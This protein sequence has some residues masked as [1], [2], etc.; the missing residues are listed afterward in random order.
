[1]PSGTKAQAGK[2]LATERWFMKSSSFVFLKTGFTLTDHRRVAMR[3]WHIYS[4]TIALAF[5]LATA[6]SLFRTWL[7]RHWEIGVNHV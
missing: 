2:Q 4:I 3:G 6:L 5:A 1:V 7:Y